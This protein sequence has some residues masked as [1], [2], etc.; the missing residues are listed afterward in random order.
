MANLDSKR[1]GLG[2]VVVVVSVAGV[3]WSNTRLTPSGT[4]PCNLIWVSERDCQY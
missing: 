1:T 2:L 4:S 3:V